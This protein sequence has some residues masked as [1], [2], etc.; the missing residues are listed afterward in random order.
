MK[1]NNIFGVWH[2]CRICGTVF[3]G[4]FELHEHMSVHSKKRSEFP[5]EPISDLAP[6]ELADRAALKAS[7]QLEF[8][9]PS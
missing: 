1:R 3:A 7:P 4:K 8:S 2:R 9:P 6:A 5:D